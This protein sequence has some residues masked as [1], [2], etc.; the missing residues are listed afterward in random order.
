M[1]VIVDLG[2]HIGT[3]I[4]FF[5]VRH[6]GAEIHGFEPDPRTFARLR[7]NVGALPGVTIDPR[8]ASG[9]GGRATFHSAGNSLASSLIADAGGP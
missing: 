6:P 1:R 9:S 4:L 7:A 8:A 5:R 3:S 2:S